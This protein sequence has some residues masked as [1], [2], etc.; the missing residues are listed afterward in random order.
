MWVETLVILVSTDFVV[1]N[2]INQEYE[3]FVHTN[4]QVNQ[5]YQHNSAVGVF[6]CKVSA[7]HFKTEKKDNIAG[8]FG[9]SS[10]SQKQIKLGLWF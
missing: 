8:K 9:T 5:Q 3:R 2:S 4:P 6:M 1:K 10:S 7:S